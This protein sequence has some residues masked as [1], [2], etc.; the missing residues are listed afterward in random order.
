V[1]QGNWR[2]V[3]HPCKGKKFNEIGVYKRIIPNV[4]CRGVRIDGKERSYGRMAAL[5]FFCIRGH[6]LLTRDCESD[7]NKE[8]A[9]GAQQEHLAAREA[10]DNEGRQRG[11]D[12]V[13]TLAA[14]VYPCFCVSGVEPNHTEDSGKIV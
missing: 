3:A 14:H 5:L 8:H 7:E 6:H 13:P 1:K 11:G 4:V 2:D 10:R 12:Q 9:A